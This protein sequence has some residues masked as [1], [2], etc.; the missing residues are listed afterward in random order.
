MEK[1]ISMLY[2]VHTHIQLVVTERIFLLPFRLFPSLVMWNL[3][4]LGLNTFTLY[5]ST[6]IMMIICIGTSDIS[7]LC[8]H[9]FVYV[10]VYYSYE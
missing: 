5:T 7:M 2:S 3:F 1:Y 8:T 6:Y 10:C 9:L 4:S